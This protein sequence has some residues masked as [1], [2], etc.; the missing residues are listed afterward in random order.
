MVE[1]HVMRTYKIGE[2]SERTGLSLRT[3][4]YYEELGLIHARRT[5]GGQRLYS[6]QEMIYLKRI[7]ELKKL[8][9]SLEEISRIINLKSED[10]SGN[11]RRDELLRKYR[12]RYSKEKERLEAL[13]SHVAELEW[14]IHQLERDRDG[15]TSC[16]GSSCVSCEYTDKC[17]FFKERE[18]RS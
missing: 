6:D 12:K 4:R 1:C 8:G 17:I 15:F 11:K 10:E 2:L 13:K 16:P 7:T 14:H 3:I 5:S 9:F 18:A